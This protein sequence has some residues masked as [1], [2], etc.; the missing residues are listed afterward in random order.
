M[1]HLKPELFSIGTHL[2]A[3]N[4]SAS[5]SVDDGGLGY[6]RVLTTMEGMVQE[7]MEWNDWHRQDSIANVA[8]NKTG[9]RAYQSSVSLLMRSMRRRHGAL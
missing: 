4:D 5:R 3:T 7:V 6:K 1:K 2:V 9:K 8:S